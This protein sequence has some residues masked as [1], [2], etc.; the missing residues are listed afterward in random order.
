MRSRASSAGRSKVAG[1]ARADAVGEVDLQRDDAGNVARIGSAPLAVAKVRRTGPI[2]PDEVAFSLKTVRATFRRPRT[3]T[4]RA[5][6]HAC[7]PRRTRDLGGVQRGGRERKDDRGPGRRR[8]WAA[9]SPQLV[10][11]SRSAC[12]DV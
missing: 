9:M 7:V 1:F 3:F 12:V 5:A 11:Q 10:H 2:V 6:A 8:F 4:T